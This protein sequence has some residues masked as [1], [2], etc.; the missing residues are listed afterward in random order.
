VIFV[1]VRHE[2]G[3]KLVG[4]LAQ[5]GEIVDDDVDAEHFVIGEHQTAVDD[6]Q[7]VASFDDRHVPADLAA[8]AEGHDANERLV[9]RSWYDERVSATVALIQNLSL[10][11]LPGHLPEGIG[12]VEVI[13]VFLSVF[14]VVAALTVSPPLPAA[15]RV[16]TSHAARRTI[17]APHRDR[18]AANDLYAARAR[19]RMAS[20]LRL[21]LL[22]L[23][24]A[25][26]RR[27]ADVIERRL[28]IDV[29]T[30]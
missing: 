14:G 22:E 11:G 30:R 7:V 27:A 26:L 28:P 21:R 19:R 23:R 3:P 20:Y 18:I 5:I 10:S 1:P 16:R 6:D 2:Q 12:S 9:G 24:M 8:A 15:T 13:P 25:G 29:L 4:A 17:A